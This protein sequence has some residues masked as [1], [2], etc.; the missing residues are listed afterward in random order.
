MPSKVRDFLGRHSLRFMSFLSIPFASVSCIALAR[1]IL[2][3]FSLATFWVLVKGGL[4]FCSPSLLSLYIRGARTRQ[5]HRSLAFFCFILH[6]G[7]DSLSC[8][9][10]FYCCN[11]LTRPGVSILEHVYGCSGC[12][13][14]SWVVVSPRTHFSELSPTRRDKSK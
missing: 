3:S 1:C 11:G 7:F 12:S 8:F 2:H 5:E 10:H 6:R 14:A 13:P 4:E 9:L